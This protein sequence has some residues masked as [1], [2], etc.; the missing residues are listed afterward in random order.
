[1][2]CVSSSCYIRERGESLLSLL[3]S[4]RRSGLLGCFEACI[5]GGGGGDVTRGFG[6]E[7]F[8][9]SG[10]K[11]E[12][13]NG[14]ANKKPSAINLIAHIVFPFCPWKLV[15]KESQNPFVARPAVLWE[16]RLSYLSGGKNN[17]PTCVVVVSR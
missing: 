5:Q 12:R 10:N 6:E 2:N 8:A 14:A 3:G 13:E 15:I 4:S 11:R 7:N 16:K 9:S 1:M 17:T